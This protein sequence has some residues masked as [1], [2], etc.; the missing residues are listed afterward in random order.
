[1]G[2]PLKEAMPQAWVVQEIE[3]M[4]PQEIHHHLCKQLN[5][6]CAT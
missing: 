4:G 3:F 1:V 2:N 6:D 5:V